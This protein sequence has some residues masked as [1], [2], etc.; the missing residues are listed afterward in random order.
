MRVRPQILPEVSCQV[1][2]TYVCVEAQSVLFSSAVVFYE[3]V[4]L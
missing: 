2:R 1:P 3:R 4:S